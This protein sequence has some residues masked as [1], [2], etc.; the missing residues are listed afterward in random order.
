M[1]TLSYGSKILSWKE[2]TE[3]AERHNHFFQ[4]QWSIQKSSS[5]EHMT[6]YVLR[7]EKVAIIDFSGKIPSQALHPPVWKKKHTF[8]QIA[9]TL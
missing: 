5:E 7:P 1:S 9:T 8:Y 3:N 6:I 2:G 4:F